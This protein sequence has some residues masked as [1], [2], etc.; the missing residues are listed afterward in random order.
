MIKRLHSNTH[1]LA[2]LH[3]KPM[4]FYI[5]ENQLMLLLDTKWSIIFVCHTYCVQLYIHV[6]KKVFHNILVGSNG[7]LDNGQV[8]FNVFCLLLKSMGVAPILGFAYTSDTRYRQLK[9]AY[10]C[11]YSFFEYIC[12]CASIH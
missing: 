8:H 11:V 7:K 9:L 4:K 1:Y 6:V 3:R 12:S 2:I 10:T 5:Q